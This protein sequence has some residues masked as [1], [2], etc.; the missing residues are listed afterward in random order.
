MALRDPLAHL[1]V[2]RRRLCRLIGAMTAWNR[3]PRT[4]WRI[5]RCPSSWACGALRRLRSR[6]FL[7]SCTAYPNERNCGKSPLRVGHSDL[8]HEPNSPFDRKIFES[9]TCNPQLRY[10]TISLF[11]ARQR[12]LKIYNNASNLQI[13][14][15]WNGMSWLEL[16]GIQQGTGVARHATIR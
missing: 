8:L 15:P 10:I 13:V 5:P 4:S 7:V 14:T 1:I 11:R 3:H 12:T 6:Y 9:Q 16:A 2:P